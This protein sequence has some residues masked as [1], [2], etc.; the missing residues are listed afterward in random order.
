MSRILRYAIPAEKQ[1]LGQ[2]DGSWRACKLSKAYG[3]DDSAVPPIGV[4]VQH[5]ALLEAFD[6]IDLEQ[7]QRQS[8]VEGASRGIGRVPAIADKIRRA[9][10]QRMAVKEAA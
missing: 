2:N 10:N 8:I 7:I 3:K 6:S 5:R 4:L 9:L 1:S